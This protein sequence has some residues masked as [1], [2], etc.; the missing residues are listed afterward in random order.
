MQVAR[1]FGR[2][3]RRLSDDVVQREEP[4][5]EG[6]NGDGNRDEG[7]DEDR[8][9]DGSGEEVGGRE[10]LGT[11][12]VIRDG[13]QD[14]REGVTPT[15]NQQPQPQDPTPQRDRRTMQM[16]SA[17]EREARDMELIGAGRGGRRR[18]E[19]VQETSEQL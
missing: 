2:K 5:R 14:A 18:G 10:S 1:S 19:E 13:A 7:R 3:T 15:S 11:F 4:E 9:K 17:K 12:E 8:D 6:G 16:P